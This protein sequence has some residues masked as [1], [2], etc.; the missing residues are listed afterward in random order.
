MASRRCRSTLTQRNL[1]GAPP[2]C[3]GQVAMAPERPS[4]LVILDLRSPNAADGGTI[5]HWD[6]TDAKR[7]LLVLWEASRCPADFIDT[8]GGVACVSVPPG[9]QE[10]R[11]P[12]S[13]F[14]E[15]LVE[16][17]RGQPRG[18][19]LML[20]AILPP[21]HLFDGPESSD[22]PSKAK[23]VGERLAVYWI[24]SGGSETVEPRWR[25]AAV[26]D[27]GK[28]IECVTEINRRPSPPLPP[29]P[30]IPSALERREWAKHRSPPVDGPP[31][32]THDN[33]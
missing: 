1:E 23:I 29:E 33:G 8:V 32:R 24:F 14:P 26:E 12:L 28:L 7:D 16:Y 4:S 19:Q 15:P 20:I 5:Y 30:P 31:P 10:Y 9:Y 6:P 3:S 22:W 25:I 17:W 21:K 11:Y 13:R 27:L 2:T 18:G